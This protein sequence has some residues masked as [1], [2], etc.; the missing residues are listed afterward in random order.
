[1]EELIELLSEVK[2]DVDFENE[3][4]LIDDG[5]LDSFDILQIIST[6][7]EEYDISIPASEIIPDNFNSAKSL[8]DMVQ[9][10]V[11]E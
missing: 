6:L 8:Y 5:I 2:E 7:N 3:T 4:A 1:M 9:R 10:L 11:E